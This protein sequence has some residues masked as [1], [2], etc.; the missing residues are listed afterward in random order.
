MSKITYIGLDKPQAV[1]LLWLVD[2]EL[3]RSTSSPETQALRDIRTM[4]ATIVAPT[5]E[6]R[7][8]AAP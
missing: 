2:R 8:R 1:R 6:E 4:L 7:E 3:N 5:R